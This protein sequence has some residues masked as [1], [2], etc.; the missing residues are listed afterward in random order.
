L[1]ESY[2][3]IHEISDFKFDIDNSIQKFE[4]HYYSLFLNFKKNF[5]FFSEI[6]KIFEFEKDK[7]K[8]KIIY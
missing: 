2:T 7:G 6:E 5:N 4:S 1:N 8:K 3:K